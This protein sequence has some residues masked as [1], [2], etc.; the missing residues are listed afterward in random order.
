MC[1]GSQRA[2]RTPS[3]WLKPWE[4]GTQQRFMGLR[5][6]ADGRAMRGTALGPSVVVDRNA[7]VPPGNGLFAFTASSAVRLSV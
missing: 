6:E 4:E 1:A 2:E 5:S 7:D 3:S